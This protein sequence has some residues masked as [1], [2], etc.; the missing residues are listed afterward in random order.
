[1]KTGVFLVVFSQ[2]SFE[3]AL[4]KAKALGL[5]TVEIGTGNYPGDAH[6]KP[7]RLLSDTDGRKR[8]LDAV[9]SRGLEISALSCHGNMLHPDPAIAR[10]HDRVF[11]DTVKLAGE[12]GV[13]VVANFSGTPGG[14]PDDKVPNW[15]T[16]PWPTDYSDALKWQWEEKLIPYWREMSRF[17]GDHAVKVGLEMH[18]G[19]CV[20]NP[21]TLLRLRQAA[22]ENI[23][24]NFDPSHLFWQGI[25]PMAAVRALQGCIYHVHAKDTMI[26][27]ASCDVN[28]VLDTKPYLDEINRS[29]IFRAVG[30]GHGKEF[31]NDLV[32]TLRMAGYDGTLSIEHEDSL[33]SGGEGLRKAAAFLNDVV[34]REDAGKAWWA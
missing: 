10:A 16:C 24:A 8:F 13:Q 25:D 34:I 1:M 14:G 6:C 33:M 30:Y 22:G 26:Y 23:G 19:I 9:Q 27:R 12:L 29:W 15:I 28:G 3:N 4:D 21:E 17:C 7:D 2:D 20:Y 32:S 5:D 11:R 18:P 31:W